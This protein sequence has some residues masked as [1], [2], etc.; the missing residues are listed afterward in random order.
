MALTRTEYAIRIK[1]T[2]RYL[3]RP[4]RRDGRGGSHLEPIDFADPSSWP[5]GYE[6]DMQIRS[7][8]DERAAKCML[9]SW[10]KGGVGCHR[11]G[12]VYDDDYYEDQYIIPKPHR[13]REDMEIVKIQITL[14]D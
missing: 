1:G 7:Y 6:K 9:S 3:P 8:S 14:P 2:Q 12:G 4:Q 5:K 11:G 10:L 13:R